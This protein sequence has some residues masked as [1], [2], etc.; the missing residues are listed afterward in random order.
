MLKYL[1]ILLYPVHANGKANA[2]VCVSTVIL[3]DA[4][5]NAKVYVSTVILPQVLAIC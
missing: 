2:K 4:K 3:S 1:V 5:A